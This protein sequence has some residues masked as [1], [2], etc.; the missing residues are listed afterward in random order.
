MPARPLRRFARSLGDALRLPRT[1]T[2]IVN[3]LVSSSRRLS[4]KE[5]VER[6]KVSERS[7]RGNLSLLVR[8][9]ILERHGVLTAKNRLAY[10]YRLRTREELLRAVSVQFARNLT[11]LRRSR[12]RASPRSASSSRN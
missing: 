5:I 7:V 11:A 12:V 9:G 3:L 4:V 2:A 8:R 1:A 6:V 10:L